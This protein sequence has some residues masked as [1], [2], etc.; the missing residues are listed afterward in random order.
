MIIT[1]VTFR[2]AK[3]WTAAEATAVFSSTAPKYLGKNGLIRKHYFLSDGGDR[4]GG[5]YLW[6]T[7]AAADTCYAGEWR[8]IVAEKYGVEPEIQ[9]V[10]VP[11]SVDN[12]LGIIHIG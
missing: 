12:L 5:I 11:V 1:I 9:Y 10:E 2:L 3:P 7:R 6:E 4:A 8:A